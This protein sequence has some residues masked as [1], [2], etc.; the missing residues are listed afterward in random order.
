MALRQAANRA[1]RSY[2]SNQGGLHAPAASAL[3]HSDFDRLQQ[4]RVLSTN[5]RRFPSGRGGGGR[6]GDGRGGRGGG[7]R[8][9]GGG[10]SRVAGPGAGAGAG[11]G[12]GGGRKSSYSGPKLRTHAIS[13]MDGDYNDYENLNEDHYTAYNNRVKFKSVNDLDEK[14]MTPDQLRMKRLEEEALRKH[15]EEQAQKAKWTEN[16]KPHVRT[17]VIDAKG[18]S[19]GKGGRKHATSRVWIQPGEGVITINKREFVNFF[20]RYTHREMILGPFVATNTCGKFDV[21]A[22]VDGGG[23]SGKAGAIRH[24]IARALEKYYPDYRPPMKLLGFMKRDPRM[25]ESKKVGLK[26]ARKAP[27]WVRR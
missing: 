22:T 27:Q 21:A 20:P 11:A 19:F 7:G 8:G 6:G 12:G 1:F 24:G 3:S 13:F 2:L 23:V 14:D 9:G 15:E 18:R 17:Q 10:G 4:C 25:V 16:A 26:K 5:G